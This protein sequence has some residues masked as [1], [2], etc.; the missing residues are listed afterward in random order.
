MNRRHIK[1]GM[2]SY[3]A[4]VP[5]GFHHSVRESILEQLQN[6]AVTVTFVGEAT[7]D[8]AAYAEK[9]AV[10]LKEQQQK[11]R[12]KHGEIEGGCA[13]PVGS[14]FDETKHTH[15]GY[16]DQSQPICIGDGDLQG[17]VWTRIETDAPEEMLAN[18]LRIVGP[19][20]SLVNVW[21]N[22][23]LPPSQ[24]LEEAIQRTQDLVKS[25]DYPFKTAMDLWH[26][27]V[28][29]SWDLSEEELKAIDDKLQGKMAMKYRLSCIRSDSVSYEYTRRE[30]LSQAAGIVVPDVYGE[31]WEVDLVDYDV[32][33]VLLVHPYALAVGLSLRPYRQLE[34]RSF[35]KGSMPA[36]TSRPHLSAETLASVIRLRPSTAQIL[37]H[38]AKLE[39]GDVVLDPCSGVGT[40]P[41]ETM[42]HKTQGVLSLGGDLVLTPDGLGPIAAMY[43][44]EAQTA[45]PHSSRSCVDQ[46]A[47]DTTGLP[48][49]DGCVDV[50]VSDLPF[51]KQCLSRSKLDQILPLMFSEM[52]RVLRP[53]TGR[54][55]MLCGAYHQ[56]VYHLQKLNSGDDSC[57]SP[58]EDVVCMPC[59]SIFPVNIGGL[60]SWIVIVKRGA[61]KAR[62]FP[63]HRERAKILTGKRERNTKQRK[64]A[65]GKKKRSILQTR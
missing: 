55:V 54:M 1:M 53:K 22:I 59:S 6:F 65:P 15:L 38:L 40:I 33:V 58:D 31:V 64:H 36:D 32:E 50:V 57:L 20:V 26:K 34:M 49:R 5:R 17:T 8:E 27:H 47:W 60:L 35:S 28:A 9:V 12:S 42:F 51:G 37:L 23:D 62:P 46:T 41:M 39:P 11:K 2:S 56:V 48:L 24:S 52:I 18:H 25:Q 61:A 7:N 43:F 3:L 4:L 63:S 21:E 16:L 14:V 29:S 30:Y 19:L 44:R 13:L 10:S 45:K